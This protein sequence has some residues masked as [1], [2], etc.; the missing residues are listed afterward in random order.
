VTREI[1]I[2]FANVADPIGAGFITSLS[3]P[4]G[5]ITGF[6]NIEATTRKMLGLLNETTPTIKRAAFPNE[7]EAGH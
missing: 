4:G 6:I 5:N 7:I 2:V 1:P 3:R